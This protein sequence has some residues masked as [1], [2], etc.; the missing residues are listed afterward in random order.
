MNAEK[1]LQST[2]ELIAGLLNDV[3]AVADEIS[4]KVEDGYLILP[5]WQVT[6][7]TGYDD[8]HTSLVAAATKQQATDI[9]A[10]DNPEAEVHAHTVERVDFEAFV[11]GPK[12]LC[13]RMY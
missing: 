8:Y 6:S 13:G 10:I 4:Q 1:L 7:V 11:G 5:V 3:R 12:V 2:N 9:V